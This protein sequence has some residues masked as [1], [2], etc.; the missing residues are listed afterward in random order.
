MKAMQFNLIYLLNL[1]QYG[2]P[3]YGARA[4]TLSSPTVYLDYSTYSTVY[5]PIM[6]NANQLLFP[7]ATIFSGSS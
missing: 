4:V 5:S 3:C 2:E 6:K 1:N 7:P